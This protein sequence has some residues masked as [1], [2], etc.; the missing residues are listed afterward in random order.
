MSVLYDAP[1]YHRRPPVLPRG[2]D[3]AAALSADA[4]V[5]REQLAYV[6]QALRHTRNGY[7][8]LM[9][10]AGVAPDTIRSN[11]AFADAALEQ[12]EARP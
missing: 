4:A 2:L 11:V 10:F 12:F 6:L 7:A 1:A 3:S 8:A 9:Q 5:L